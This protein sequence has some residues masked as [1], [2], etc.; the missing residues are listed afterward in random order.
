MKLKLWM[1]PVCTEC[2]WDKLVF[3]LCVHVTHLSVTLGDSM[4]EPWTVKVC[5]CMYASVIW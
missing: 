5:A 1:L 3:L 2:V 4:L